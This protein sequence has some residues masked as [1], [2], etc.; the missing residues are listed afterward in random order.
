MPVVAAEMTDTRAPPREVRRQSTLDDFV[1]SPPR[2]AAAAEES[3]E[4]YTFVQACALNV[5]W[6]GGLEHRSDD[7]DARW[8]THA[9]VL[10][11]RL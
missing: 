9:R 11:P 2:A 3:A 8:Q 7:V 6:W 1:G 10:S 5:C 4:K